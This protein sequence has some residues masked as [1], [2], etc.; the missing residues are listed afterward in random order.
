MKLPEDLRDRLKDPKGRL[1]SNFEDALSYVNSIQPNRIVT[2]GDKVTASFL[3]EGVSPDL[4]IADF[5]I[6]RKRA[7]DEIKDIIDSYSVPARKIDNPP[8]QISEELLECIE[9][10]K[11]PAKVIVEGEEDLATIPAT[12]NSPEGSAVVYGQPDEG[13]VV[14]EVTEEKK[15]EFRELWGLFE[16]DE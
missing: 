2:V 10:V 12:L 4:V 9:E 1:F 15:A 16:K 7:N 5:K 3:E 6:K 14:I 11:P 8:G 13:I